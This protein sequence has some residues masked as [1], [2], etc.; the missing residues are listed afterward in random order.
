MKKGAFVLFL[1]GII[2]ISSIVCAEEK[3]FVLTK[4]HI[5]EDLYMHNCNIWSSINSSSFECRWASYTKCQSLGYRGGFGIQK[6][7]QAFQPYQDNGPATSPYVDILCLGEDVG[8]YKEFSYDSREQ[9]SIDSVL[10]INCDYYLR[11]KCKSLG[12]YS[13][14]GAIGYNK[15]AIAT[16]CIKSSPNAVEMP[17]TLGEVQEV[18]KKLGCVSSDILNGNKCQA[19]LHLFCVSKGYLS[20]FEAIEYNPETEKGLVVCVK[21]STDLR[22]VSA[23][24]DEKTRSTYRPARI[25]SNIIGN[26]VNSASGTYSDGIYNAFDYPIVIR[27]IASSS[28]FKKFTMPYGKEAC[29]FLNN[30]LM[31]QKSQTND[32]GE[33]FCLPSDSFDLPNQYYF[34]RGVLL[35][36]GEKL[37]FNGPVD[38]YTIPFPS[39][40]YSWANIT[41]S[42]IDNVVSIR[43]IRFPQIDS[44]YD[45]N[46]S[47]GTVTIHAGCDQS[48]PFSSYCPA[49]R[50]YGG[51]NFDQVNGGEIV[52]DLNSN[53]W[54]NVTE[55]TYI[56]GMS[57]YFTNGRSPG[58]QSLA[59]CLRVANQAGQDVIAPYCFGVSDDYLTPTSL[60]KYFSENIK[61]KGSS[62]VKLDIPV[63]KGNLVGIDFSFKTE[64]SEN[65]GMD[66]AGYIWIEKKVQ[67]TTCSEENWQ[68]NDSICG[69]NGQKTRAW[70]K[71]GICSGGVNKPNSEMVACTSKQITCT[72]FSYTPWGECKSNGIQ[73]RNV[74]DAFPDGC[75]GGNFQLKRACKFISNKSIERNGSISVNKKTNDTASNGTFFSSNTLN[76]SLDKIILILAVLVFIVVGIFYIW[77]NLIKGYS[78][79]RYWDK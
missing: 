41:I 52:R 62:F 45:M 32:S 4:A 10:S 43:R 40:Y 27:Y 24:F 35:Y 17:F 50:S 66:F 73:I 55:D 29:F 76:I 69:S 23:N 57:V 37:F 49:L 2:F 44:T 74:T 68:Y 51:I 38:G 18:D 54:Y 3:G 36:P 11:N 33:L 72:S 53:W 39:G 12:Y 16:F 14:S 15:N 22:G 70:T 19:N 31:G 65:V 42:S 79:D 78:S 30:H 21:G 71:I 61:T 67:E 8:D 63:K 9:C 77:L 20:G 48:S 25:G 26:I 58:I 5:I 7:K 6:Y 13:S 1:F 56:R 64:S 34:D 46:V 75:I 28:N 47:K 59:A 60:D